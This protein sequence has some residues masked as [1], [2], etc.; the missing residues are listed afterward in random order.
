MFVVR[1]ASVP[2]STVGHMGSSHF[3]RALAAELRR[4]TLQHRMGPEHVALA[5]GL[6]VATVERKWGGAAALES[7]EL[8]GWCHFLDVD[9]TTVWLRVA[10]EGSYSS[11]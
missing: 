3:D 10:I 11:E 8:D 4:L 2:V 7:D 9:P 6:P 5:I 1:F